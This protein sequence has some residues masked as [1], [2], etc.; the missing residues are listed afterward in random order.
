MINGSNDWQMKW[1]KIGIINLGREPYHSKLAITTPNGKHHLTWFWLKCTYGI[2]S[3]TKDHLSKTLYNH[4][5]F[6]GEYEYISNK[7]REEIIFKTSIFF[8]LFTKDWKKTK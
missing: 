8:N 2:G 3:T 1:E 4:L 7:M 5:P 6:N